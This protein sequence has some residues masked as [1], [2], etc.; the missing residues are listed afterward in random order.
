MKKI[1]FLL[2][3][4]SLNLL[5]AQQFPS[6]YCSLNESFNSGVEEITQ[7]SFANLN[8]TN[9][10]TNSLLVNA[11]NKTAEIQQLTSNEIIIKGNTYGEY[12]NLIELYIDWNKNNDFTDEG[13]YYN[14]GS[15]T[16]STGD[17]DVIATLNILVPQTSTLGLTR[18]RVK[19]T[20][21]DSALQSVSS[22]CSIIAIDTTNNEES[23]NY[24]Q[25][26]DFT[27]N[28]ISATSIP[29][30]ILPPTGLSTQTL[31]S[32]QTLEEL[33]VT[34]TN[35]KWYTDQNLLTEIPSNTIAS[36]N[37]T[38]YVTQSEGTCESTALAIT[39][40]TSAS[41]DELDLQKLKI[42]PNPVKDDI[43]ISYNEE[44]KL[45]TIYDVLGK[46][47]LEKKATSEQVNLNLSTLTPGIYFVKI[48]TKTNKQS[49]TKILK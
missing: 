11:L 36:N 40:Q 2:N 1:I 32:N 18:V 26:L 23:Q 34:G 17:D 37:T 12:S 22:P 6:P 43:I 29:C 33:S 35:L 4:I 44:I 47:I 3:L 41:I 25:A 8:F 5:N 38:Y 49:T 48:V 28:I 9:T 14:L 19:K 45:I 42:Y 10:N 39:V 16:N 24:G 20:Y 13:E 31:T 15:I 30:E 27:I 46:K 21:I 7:V